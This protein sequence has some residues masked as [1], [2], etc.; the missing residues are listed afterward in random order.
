MPR[1]DEKAQATVVALLRA[2]YR[3]SQAALQAGVSPQAVR[4]LI[5]AGLDASGSPMDGTFAEEVA[6]AEDAV[7]GSVET[8]LLEAA[9]AGEPWAITAFLKAKARDEYGD[10]PPSINVNNDNRTVNIGGT[11]EDRVNT[12]SAL[13]A[14]LDARRALTSGD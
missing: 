4:T 8:K 5:R 9:Q 2:G 13:A 11:A 1:F 14:E 7:I 10:K 6:N 12:I 3:R